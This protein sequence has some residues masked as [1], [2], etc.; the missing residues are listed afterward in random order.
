MKLCSIDNWDML[1]LLLV[2]YRIAL[3]CNDV[4][5]TTSN[6]I[7]EVVFNIFCHDKIII[8]IIIII[9]TS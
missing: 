2:V 5:G 7:F 8:I 6:S 3:K 4:I 9:I 1:C